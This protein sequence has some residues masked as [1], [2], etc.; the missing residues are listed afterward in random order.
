M[1]DEDG[2]PT[3]VE[4][5]AILPPQSQMGAI[6]DEERDRHRKEDL[7][8]SRYV[9]MIDRDSAYEFLQRKA[10]A[11]ADA[12]AAQKQEEAAREAAE[13]GEAAREKQVR[14]T[15]GK[16]ASTAAGTVGRQILGDL[17]GQLGGSFGKRLGGNVGAS[18]GRGI[19]STLFKR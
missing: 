15:I 13:E 18:L 7:L 12:E 3:M 10:L 14:S 9:E 19:L 5:C 16:V 11:D 8:Y 2:V 4:R 17:G 1:L 6:E